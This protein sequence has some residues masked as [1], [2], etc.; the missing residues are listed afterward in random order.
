MT[1]G[2]MG[3]SLAFCL[4]I[5]ADVPKPRVALMPPSVAS[6]GEAVPPEWSESA[7]LVPLP[8]FGVS[9]DSGLSVWD[10]LFSVMPQSYWADR[11]GTSPRRVWAGSGR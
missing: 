3:Q 5:Q 8:A 9:V 7:G 6:S 4:C 10:S 11:A 1:E 2:L